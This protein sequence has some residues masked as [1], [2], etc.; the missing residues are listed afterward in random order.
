[1]GFLHHL[2]IRARLGLVIAILVGVVCVV[3]AMGAKGMIDGFRESDMLLKEHVEPAILL[4]E[5]RLLQGENRTQ[6]LLSLQHD[7]VS[8]FVGMHDHQ[9]GFHT[10]AVI[11]NAERISELLKAYTVRRMEDPREKELFAKFSESRERYFKD[12][13]APA[14]EALLVGEYL[15]ANEIILKKVNPLYKVT[16]EAGEA[17]QSHILSA[18]KEEQVAH[19]R[20]FRAELWTVGLLAA[21]G[22]VLA[23]IVGAFL[24]RSIVRPLNDLVKQFEAMESGDLRQLVVVTERQELGRVQSALASLQKS[25]VA[26]IDEVRSAAD[27][28]A[29]SAG[30]LRQ[31]VAA[32]SENSQAQQDGVMH[33][34]A[35]MDEMTVSVA[36]VAT[37]T[38]EAAAAARE[39]AELVGEGQQQVDKTVAVTDE[40]VKA[41]N[42]STSTMESLQ[43]SVGRIGS[44]TQVIKDVAEQTNLLALN[45]AIEA[46]RAGKQGRGFAVVADEVR[47][48]AER[49]AASTADITRIVEEVR[50]AADQAVQAMGS[51]GDRVQVAQVSVRAGGDA[52]QR[53]SSAAVRVNSLTQHIADASADQSAAT[54]GVAQNMERISALIADTH[55][56]IGG[57][58][59]AASELAATAGRLEALVGRFRTATA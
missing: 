55:L 42:A 54:S 24:H 44:V 50:V 49:T 15:R 4:N 43:Q 7:P 53:V 26:M 45:A 58:E 28:V 2:S 41:V 13:L 31:E 30:H 57:V 46:A 18:A 6:L 25:L 56:R 34:S 5:I 35:A 21:A 36:E 37:S 32:V 51:A 11:K 3:G 12:G 33:V 40:V 23:L 14:R 1:M 52:L 47:K 38:S 39:S 19:E 9:L 20:N 59:S 17:L 16:R 8:P 10:D 27:S 29:G 22:V 48:L